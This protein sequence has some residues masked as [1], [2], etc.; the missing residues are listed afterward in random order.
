MPL[1]AVQK[2]K[3]WPLTDS[4]TVSSAHTPSVSGDGLGAERGRTGTSLG[5]LE[6]P[7]SPA[8]PAPAV[9]PGGR[10]AATTEDDALCVSPGDDGGRRPLP[11][12]HSPDDRRYWWYR[13]GVG[14][15]V[16]VRVGYWSWCRIGGGV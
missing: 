7:T 1:F 15:G 12:R 4:T 9:A 13:I 11:P 6:G 5:G 16:G 14:V 2:V 10:G 8:V 3:P